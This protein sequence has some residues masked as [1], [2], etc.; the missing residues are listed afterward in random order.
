MPEMEMNVPKLCREH[1]GI[2]VNASFAVFVDS[3]NALNVLIR[4]LAGDGFDVT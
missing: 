3:L 2:T 4:R 1:A